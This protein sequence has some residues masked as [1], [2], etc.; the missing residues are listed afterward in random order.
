MFRYAY[1]SFTPRGGRGGGG[2]GGV[3]FPVSILGIPDSPFVSL[4]V[5]DFPVSVAMLYRNFAIIR[6]TAQLCRNSRL[7]PPISSYSP[8]SGALHAFS[9]HFSPFLASFLA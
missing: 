7:E 8:F 5:V 6:N 2:G 4:P 1:K 3:P 9:K